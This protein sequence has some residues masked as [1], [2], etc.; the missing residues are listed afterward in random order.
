MSVNKE[1]AERVRRQGGFAVKLRV[2]QSSTYL[3][4]V[5]AEPAKGLRFVTMQEGDLAE[6]VKLVKPVPE[7]VR[8]KAIK[9]VGKSR[10][11][12]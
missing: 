10:K 11:T 9:K 2:K 4:L 8:R 7:K 12:R 1:P 5:K 6:V 3:G